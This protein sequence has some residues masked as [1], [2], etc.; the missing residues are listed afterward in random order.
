MKLLNLGCGDQR[1]PGDEWTNLDDLHSQFGLDRPERMTL[2][3]EPNYFNYRVDPDSTL[4]FPDGHFDGILASHF[5]E[6]WDAQECL[7]IMKD[8]RRLLR[9]GG[10]L[11]VSVPDASY[12]RKVHAEDRNENW[13]RLFGVTDPGNPIPT[14]MEAALFFEQ[15]KQVITEDALWC[16]LTDCGFRVFDRPRE[17]PIPSVDL[18]HYKLNRIP[19]SLVM[20]GIK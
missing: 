9:D 3:M 8:C 15:H 16:M 14:W 7:K 10:C 6:H 12:F 13:Q 20:V 2:D 19:F 11:V 5:F 17:T 4:P 18:I 1:F